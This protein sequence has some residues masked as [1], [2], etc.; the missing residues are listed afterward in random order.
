MTGNNGHGELV[1]QGA[2][3]A[4]LPIS[5]YPTDIDPAALPRGQQITWE[6]QEAFFKG[7]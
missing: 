3:P 5:Q 7:L 4:E 6:R 2:A 1:P